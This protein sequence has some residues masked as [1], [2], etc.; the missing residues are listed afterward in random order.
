LHVALLHDVEESD[1]NFAGEVGDFVDGEDTAVSAGKEA[2][3]H[4]QLAAEVLIAAGGFDGV[5]VADQI[6]YG[7][8]GCGEFFYEAI[9]WCKPRYGRV[10]S[11]ARDEVAAELGDGG[12]RIVT[13]L[14]AGDVGAG[15]V[16][17]GGQRAKDARLGLA[18]E[19]EE[20]E[21]VLAEDGVD[22][23]GDDGVFV[24]D[25]A[26]EERGLRLVL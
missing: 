21:V 17:E 20:D 16:E 5:D 24:A 14:G 8:V 26:G 2:V 11:E 18:A 10:F 12:V 6:G 9:I 1:L 25:D 15:G 19:A 4:R 22:E 13:H 23:L 7:D 3:V